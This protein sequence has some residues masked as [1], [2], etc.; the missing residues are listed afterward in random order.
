MSKRFAL[1]RFLGLSQ[2]EI[3]EN[4]QMWREENVDSETNL[5]AQAEMRSMGVTSAGLNTDAETLGQSDT[6]PEDLQMDGMPE[7]PPGG[8]APSAPAT[9]PA[10]GAGGGM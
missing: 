8:G 7:A 6:G 2:E 5:S 3:A 1:K 4:E 10:G 9:P